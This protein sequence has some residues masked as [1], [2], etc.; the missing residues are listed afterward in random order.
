MQNAEIML[1]DV[2]PY[3]DRLKGPV[4]RLHLR[5]VYQVL[6]DNLN[7]PSEIVICYT[8]RGTVKGGTATA[9]RMG[10]VNNAPILNLGVEYIF[11]N[12]FDMLAE[13]FS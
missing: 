7:T 12:A 13:Y 3:Y 8:E 6:G 11:N 2:L 10:G 4:K 1:K 5:N 9:I